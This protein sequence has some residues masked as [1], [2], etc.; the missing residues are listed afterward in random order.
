MATQP[1]V[2]P[3]S[4]EDAIAK[5]RAAEDLWNTRD[6]N[7]VALAYSEDSRWRNRTTW[8]HGHEEIIAF[9]KQKWER[10]LD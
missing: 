3:F 1:I 4:R 7:R 9:L 2:P 8:V 5:V 10:E 6:P